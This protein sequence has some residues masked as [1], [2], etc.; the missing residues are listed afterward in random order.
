MIEFA[1]RLKMKLSA[2]QSAFLWGGAQ[3]RQI[4]LA[5]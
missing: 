5:P 1:R 4:D 2:G 3:N